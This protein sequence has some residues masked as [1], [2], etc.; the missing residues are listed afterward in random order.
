MFRRLA[1]LSV[2]VGVASC[3]KSEVQGGAGQGSPTTPAP[4]APS[5]PSLTVFALAEMRGQIGPCGC[6]SD[7]LGDISRTTQV[8]ADA[9]AKGPVLVLDAGSLLYSAA[10]IPAHLAAQEELKADLL[11]K[12]YKD[13]LRVAAVGLGWADLPAGTKGVRFARTESNVQDAS[14]PV[15]APQVLAAGG[16]KVGVFGVIEKDAAKLDLADPVETGKAAVGKLRKDGAQIVVALVQASSKRDATSLVRDIGG[17]DLAIAGLGQAAPEPNEVEV[18]ATK[19]GDGWLV[20][21]V[22]RGQI[23]PRIDLYLRGAGPLVDAVGPAAAEAKLAQMDRQLASLDADLAKFAADPDADAS[24]VA[25]KKA[26]RE[27]LAAQRADLKAHPLV[28]PQTGSYFT[29]QQIKINRA[30]A[31]SVSVQEQVKQYD[32]AAGE[33]NLAAAA[34]KKV[35]APP[36]GQASYVGMDKCDDCHSDEVAFWKKTV[37]AQAWQTLVDRGQEYDF[38]CTGCHV[39][40]WEKPG[41]TNLAHTDGLRDVQCETCHGP[42]SIHVAKGGEERPFAVVRNPPKDLCA[43]Q[44]HTKEHSDTFQYEAYLRDIVGPGH[45]PKAREKLGNGPTGHELRK[46][47]IDKAGRQVGANCT[48]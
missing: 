13:E 36:K 41:G 2:V 38:S 31:C 28:V 37:H 1:A 47:A 48:R 33:A 35:P 39:T 5:H 11:A 12:I 14:Y 19:V 9:R 34:Q 25:T 22:N 8:V 29:L 17:I 21:P 3:S 46:A 27:Q 44:C 43:S 10:P 42:G 16:A 7:P 30:L 6:T 32:K 4:A 26:E 40:G 45:D 23:V 20:I 18:Q 24:F 15:V